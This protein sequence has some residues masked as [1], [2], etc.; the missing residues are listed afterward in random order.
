MNVEAAERAIAKR[1]A[2]AKRSLV[3]GAVLAGS[4]V[5]LVIAAA[6]MLTDRAL[7]FIA[8]SLFGFACMTGLASVPLGI[9]G[10]FGLVRV[11]RD[12]R[13]LDDARLPR[14]TLQR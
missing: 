6:A 7:G 9:R 10:L 8:V 14:A 1:H 5:W 13:A 4:S 11:A 12:R 3:I 2:S